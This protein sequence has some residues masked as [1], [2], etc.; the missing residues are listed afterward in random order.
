MTPEQS[1]R[2]IGE[3]MLLALILS[4]SLITALGAFSAWR[5][6]RRNARAMAPTERPR[7][8]WWMRSRQT[9][10]RK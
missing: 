3:L 10:E 4:V 1:Q 6:Q 9:T 7:I 8:G 5:L 2:L